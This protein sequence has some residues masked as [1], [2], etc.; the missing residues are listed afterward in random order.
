MKNDVDHKEISAVLLPPKLWRVLPEAVR[1]S[2]CEALSKSDF[3][4]LE[5]IRL[6]DGR[7]LEA[8]IAGRVRIFNDRILDADEIGA[9]FKSICG[10]SLYVHLETLRKGYITLDGGIRIGIVG[11]VSCEDGKIVGLSAVRSLCIRIPHVPRV[12]AEKIC[13]LIREGNSV[14]IYSKAGE[15]KT[16]L[17]RALA[18]R[19]C[20]SHSPDSLGVTVVDTRDEL[21][22]GIEGEGKRVDVLSGYPKGEGIEIATRVM[23]PDVIVCDEIGAG[24]VQEL[25][26]CSNCGVSIVASA[27]AKSIF[28]LL[29]REGIK[30]LHKSGVFSYYVGISRSGDQDGFD[31][32]IVSREEADAVFENNR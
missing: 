3:D 31:Y 8:K 6:R 2:L 9:C 14:L 21:V 5:E 29:N 25:L 15:G 10:T 27:H 17:L 4:S 24:E 1:I 16:T 23:A 18:S 30:K 20:D 28:E 11:E 7:M 26:L 13:G 22:F 19:L 12:R 32:D